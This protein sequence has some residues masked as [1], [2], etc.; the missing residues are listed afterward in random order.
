[1]YHERWLLRV[2]VDQSNYSYQVYRSS[3]VANGDKILFVLFK[4][5]SRMVFL[6]CLLSAGTA[7]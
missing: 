5:I 2:N 3:S 7:F 6:F 1:M 4:K